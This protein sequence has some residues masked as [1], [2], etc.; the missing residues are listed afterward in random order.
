MTGM[1]DQELKA[2]EQ[3][4]ELLKDLVRHE[5]GH[6]RRFMEAPVYDN[7]SP[8]TIATLLLEKLDEK[9]DAEYARRWRAGAAR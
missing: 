9:L 8:A 5:T 1:T 2:H 7:L 4:A 6:A 3:V